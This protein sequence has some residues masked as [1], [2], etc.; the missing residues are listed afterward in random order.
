MTDRE[1]IA[2]AHQLSWEFHALLIFDASQLRN[3]SKSILQA[4]VKG[5]SRIRTI[6]HY[7]YLRK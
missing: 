5:T 2:S 1:A 7:F 3:I 4:L 6:K